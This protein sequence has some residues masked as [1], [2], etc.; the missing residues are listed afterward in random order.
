MGGGHWDINTYSSYVNTTKSASVDSITGKISGNFS[1]Q[2]MFT[3]RRLDDALNIKN[4]IRECCDSEEHPRTVPVILGMD[5]TGS[6]GAGAVE[7]AKSL[8]PIM[9][10][11][12]AEIADVQF[13]IMGIGD[14]AYDDAPVQVSQFE[15]DIRIAEQLDKIYFEAHGGGNGFESYTAA[16]WVGLNCCALDCWKRGRK[17]LII[18]TGD[19]PLNP[20]LPARRLAEISGKG[21]EADIDTDKLYHDALSKFEIHHIAIDDYSTSYSSYTTAIEKTWGKLLGEAYHVS[22]IANLENTIV[23]IIKDFVAKND[24]IGSVP[25]GD[26]ESDNTPQSSGFVGLSGGGIAW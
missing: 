1:A 21:I 25:L 16:W 22:T 19:E 4:K 2:E 8:N 6:M 13:M 18:T 3:S 23:S 26:P 12:Y 20:Y 7:V 24:V 11:L 5:V 17:G 10:K 15:S 14:L 9:T